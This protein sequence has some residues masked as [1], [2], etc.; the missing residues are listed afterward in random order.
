MRFGPLSAD[1][2]LRR[3]KNRRFFARRGQLLVVLPLA[4]CGYMYNFRIVAPNLRGH[5]GSKWFH[6]DSLEDFYADIC[7]WFEK[8]NFKE[9]IVLV[10]H[11]LGGYL[12]AR[13]CAD[14]PDKVEKLVLMS[15]C[16]NLE[17]SFARS[18]C[19]LCWPGADLVHRLFPRLVGID[20]G[21]AENLVK[22]VFPQWDCWHIY[23]KVKAQ[24]M[25]ILGLFDPL[26]SIENGR[27]MADLIPNSRLNVISCG[28]HNPQLD[29]GEEVADLLKEFLKA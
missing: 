9:P 17:N 27:R 21:M 22:I 11:S 14:H 24:T 18:F 13:Y 25:I 20:S 29:H 16:G 10:G 4:V 26:I 12:G 23:E 15:T 2:Q 3:G 5:G 1:L 7:N 8:M 19:E 28:G 6:T